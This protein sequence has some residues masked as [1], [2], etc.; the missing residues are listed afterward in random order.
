MPAA[1]RES[2]DGAPLFFLDS[3]IVTVDEG[4][5]FPEG[6]REWRDARTS[7][8]VG[9][10]V[11]EVGRCRLLGGVAVGH[12][13]DHR[14]GLAGGDQVVQDLRGA[15][16]VQP[17]ILVTGVAVEEVEDGI[18][19]LAG[20]IARRGVDVQPAAHLEHLAVVPAGGDGA[21]RDVLHAVQVAFLPAD[22]EVVHPA[23]DV[24]HEGIVQV[25]DGLPVHGQAVE[26]H[27]GSQRRC[28]VGPYPV[29]L[30]ERGRSLH[31]L[32]RHLHGDGLGIAVAEGDA[33][34]RV[35]GDTG[36]LLLRLGEGRR[37]EKGEDGKKDDSAHRADV[38]CP[39]KYEIMGTQARRSRQVFL[40]RS[41]VFS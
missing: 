25:Q 40:G 5:N 1:H 16:Q 13:Q 30:P 21:V 27:L 37:G 24:L 32:A 29:D 17:G 4:D 10:S 2:G 8:L 19:L 14:L 6:R 22:D 26:I 20:L 41:W 18:T 12:H 35:D 36:D 23:R 28:G 3:P 31:K 7:V 33:V 11:A 39:R 9:V 34:V 15:A 38:F